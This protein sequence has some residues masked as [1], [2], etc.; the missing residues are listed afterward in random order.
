MELI[1]KLETLVQI[2]AVDSFI[3]KSAIA[4]EFKDF[5]DA[6][7][8]FAAESVS[9]IEAIITRNLKDFNKSNL[10]IFAPEAAIGLFLY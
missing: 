1:K 5:E 10:P 9:N 6:I 8:S 3:I 4:S 2:I 7:Q